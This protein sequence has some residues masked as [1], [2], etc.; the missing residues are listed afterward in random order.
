MSE[1]TKARRVP[2]KADDP[3]LV[4]AAVERWVSA[5]HDEELVRFRLLDAGLAKWKGDE[6][7][8]LARAYAKALEEL[9]AAEAG[10]RGLFITATIYEHSPTP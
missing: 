1:R 8:P 10:L 4:E 5:V 6:M 2:P 7:R 3:H 9:S